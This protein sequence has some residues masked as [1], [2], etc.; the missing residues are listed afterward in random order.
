MPNRLINEKS[1][2]LLQ[3]ST[4]PVDW[5]PWGEEAF[6][7][8]K[9]NNLPIFLSIGYSTCYWCHVMERECFE[10]EEI[11][12]LMNRNFINIKVDREERPDIDKIY[13][14]ALQSITGA[15]GWPMSMFLTPDL[16]PF[17]A[18]TYIPPKSKYG[19]AGFEDVL[20]EI[21]R[22]WN[23]KQED[24]LK[25]GD[26]VFEIL[27]SNASTEKIVANGILDES[28]SKKLFEQAK[29]YYDD[30]FGG[31][32]GGNKFPR[33]VLLNFLLCYYH[34]TE[35]VQAIDMVNYTLSGMIAGGINDRLEGG[36]HRYSVD[37]Q[38]RVP[39]FEKMLYDQAQ[40]ITL[41][42][43]AYQV[44]G[45]KLYLD[46]AVGTYDYVMKRLKNPDGGFY[47]AEDAESALDSGN[48]DIKEEG[49]YYLF[50]VD[51]L[52][53]AINQ[54]E[55]SVIKTYYGV[56]ETGNALY[57]PNEVF[58]NKNILYIKNNEFE[59]AKKM[60]MTVEEV[61]EL[62]ES[63]KEKM[64]KIRM[65]KP[66]PS[67]DDKILTNLN[68]LMISALSKMY[69]VTTDG[70][71][72]SVAR[73]TA[74]F[75]L[76]KM[77][78]KK[79]EVLFHRYKDGEV[80]F[81]GTLTDYSFLIAGLTDLYEASFDTK[82]LFV[83]FDLTEL[84]IQKFYDDEFG[85]FFD[86]EKNS[87][88]LI[89]KIKEIYDGSEPSGNSVMI[90][91]LVRLGYYV[92]EKFY[93]ENAM[94]TLEIFYSDISE[95]PFAYPN[96]VFALLEYLKSPYEIIT[97]G[98][99]DEKFYELVNHIR[100]V[101]LPFRILIYADDEL[102]KKFDFIKNIINTSEEPEIFICENYKCNLPVK[103]KEDISMILK[104]KFIK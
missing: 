87:E 11:A 34:I 42:L 74:D 6:S 80:K 76:E 15:G 9:D 86:A 54:K 27:K 33:P 22:L 53:G 14:N 72:L 48:P 85:G 35:E 29:S 46:T 94:R 61:R 88:D 52:K 73:K 78:D 39:H 57:D 64:L 31:F 60:H 66:R 82:Y 92:E 56:D 93:S 83:A 3:H 103:T 37:S 47:S 104:N 10:N 45:K 7:A 71:Y 55:L 49:H 30:E 62:L 2:Y 50:T 81:R 102:T 44:T 90:L 28:I 41:L 20:N 43:N 26:K 79:N 1:P 96:Y 69:E 4:N 99:K 101:Y 51:E 17:Y 12:E 100:S 8:A 19:R 68:A 89:I 65:A 91:N 95:N 58:R 24:I 98:R 25:S 13:M 38:W 36:F 59:T 21:S 23:T 63:A 16:K 77:Y 5:Y 18:A 84:A 40:I 67:I 32:G 70:K 97:K 75:I